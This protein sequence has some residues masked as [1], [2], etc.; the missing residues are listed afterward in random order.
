MLTHFIQIAKNTE[1]NKSNHKLKNSMIAYKKIHTNNR[2]Y[3]KTSHAKIF[4]WVC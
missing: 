1:E 3:V 2:N 4:A